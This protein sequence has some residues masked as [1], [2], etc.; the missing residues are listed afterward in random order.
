MN[1]IICRY[2]IDDYERARAMSI[3]RQVFVEE[4]R[5]FAGTDEDINDKSAIHLVAESGG[6]IVGTVRLYKESGD[7][8]VGGRLAVLPSYRGQVGASLVKRAVQEAEMQGARVFKAHV[9]KQN[10]RFFKRLGWETVERDINICGRDHVKML[11]PVGEKID[12]RREYAE[13]AAS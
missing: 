3:R 4:Q 11:G 10:E 12:G 9:Q 7:V 2:V 6:K 5:L 1:Q 13:I 8:W